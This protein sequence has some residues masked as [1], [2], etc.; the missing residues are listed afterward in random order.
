[1]P[2][3]TKPRY[4]TMERVAEILS[5]TERHVYNLV[6]EG[7]LEAIKIGTRAVRI[8]ERS[9]HEFIETARINPDDLFDPNT[10]K[11]ET[12]LPQIARSKW[13]TKP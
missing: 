7:R 3:D 11:K 8:S 6:V 4:L 9:L 1:M 10:E 13:M 5:C 12:D 2:L